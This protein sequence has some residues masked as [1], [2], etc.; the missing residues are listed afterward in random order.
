MPTM[1][2]TIWIEG[3]YCVLGQLIEVVVGL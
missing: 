2:G 3:M 1:D